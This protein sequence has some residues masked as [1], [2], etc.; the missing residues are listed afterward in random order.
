MRV[1]TEA[2]PPAT[3]AAVAE[4]VEARSGLHFSRWRCAEL[5]AKVARVFADS[6]CLTWDDYLARLASPLERPTL[7]HLIEAL[8][9]GETYFF[10]D[11]PFFEA[12]EREVL[13]AIVERRRAIRR[14]RCWCA[15]C[16]TGEEAYTLAILLRRLLPA[17]DGWQVSVLATDLNRSFLARAR[18]GLYGDWSFRAA[19][20]CFKTAYFERVGARFRIRPELHRLVHFAPLNLVEESYPSAAG[21]TLDL[22]LILCRNVLMYLA[23]ELVDPIVQRFRAALAPA[24]WLALGPSDPVPAPLVGFERHATAEA[25]FYRRVE[26]E[27]ALPVAPA[28]HSAGQPVVAPGA[29]AIDLVA[30]LDN[31]SRPAGHSRGMGTHQ[32]DGH[33]FNPFPESVDSDSLRSAAAESA[34]AVGDTTGSGEP[35]PDWREAWLAA[36]AGADRGDLA[37]AEVRCRQAI[38]LAKLRPEPYYLLGLLR[39]AQGRGEE[40][41]AAFRQSLYAD[42]TF[43]PAHLAVASFYRRAGRLDQARRALLRSQRLLAGRAADELVLV[44]EGLTVGRLGDVLA[45][46]LAALD[47][48]EVGRREGAN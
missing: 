6:G 21:G 7:D 18:A 20:E 10:R 30:L 15:G 31:R 41:L 45:S 34:S 40:A 1:E 4:L 43:V 17:Q 19:D 47:D 29:R 14:L 46:A 23:P 36:R 2:V 3:L 42:G 33:P 39:E 16:A 26:H 37:E 27:L 38:A 48:L 32:R 24:G 11:H 5:A 44:E 25:V 35:I 22:D 12:I 8:T 9:V 13:P 28:F